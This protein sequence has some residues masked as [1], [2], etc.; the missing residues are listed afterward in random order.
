MAKRL[1]VDPTT[2]TQKLEKQFRRHCKTWLS[3]EGNW[4][5]SIS[6]GIPPEAQAAKDR[7]AVQQWQTQWRDWQ[8]DGEII[9]VERQWPSL[10]KQLLPERLLIHSASD[11]ALWIG[12]SVSWERVKQRYQHWCARW[13]QLVEYLPRRFDLLADYLESDF[14]HLEKVL[15]WLSEN[16]NSNL[17]IRQLPIIGID[18]KWLE[19]RKGLLL[20]L[21]G[22]LRK[23]SPDTEKD[24]Y[25]V[26]GI[27]REPVL[28]RIRFLDERLRKQFGGLNDISAPLAEWRKT[29]L[30][31]QQVFVVENQQTGL[32]FD[33]L[34]SAIVV[35]GLGYSVNLLAEIPW[36]KTARCFYWGDL[37]VDG[38]AIL[39]CAR[40]Y[41]PDIESILM[42]EQTLLDHEELWGKD[43]QPKNALAL[44]ALNE[45]EQ[46]LYAK[47]LNN[48][49]GDRVRLE[50]ERIE[51]RYA[52]SLIRKYNS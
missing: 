46:L 35:M 45:L 32:A 10:G 27:R 24:F 50:Q 29:N 6:L 47:L 30:K 37:D 40:N 41:F 14:S 23:E 13:P 22:A 17:Y 12:E 44:T 42:D 7:V 25:Q 16:Q 2:V 11:V 15:L 4:P 9:W 19:K 20:E 51:W 48:E 38:F 1:L 8:G 21:L 26:T 52:W 33:D 18:S 36:I 39:N 31:P 43:N 5:L 3:G 49:L 28:I 34:E